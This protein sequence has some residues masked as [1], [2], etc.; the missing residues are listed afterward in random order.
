MTQG[1]PVW[2][3]DWTQ[4]DQYPDP[5]KMTREDWAWE[6]LRR[7][8]NYQKTWE[9]VRKNPD[10]YIRGNDFQDLR[11]KNEWPENDPAV[12]SFNK[13]CASYWGLWGRMTPP[14][15]T[16]ANNLSLNFTTAPDVRTTSCY[17]MDDG[18][19][20]HITGNPSG[21]NAFVVVLDLAGS[22]AS[23]VKF[24]KKEALRLKK[25]KGLS[26]GR[27]KPAKNRTVCE[28]F[29]FDLR[30]YDAT[31]CGCSPKQIAY[32]MGGSDI[33]IADVENARDRATAAVDSH[34]RK[35]P[36][37]KNTGEE[38]GIRFYF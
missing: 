15:C 3:P 16:R 12:W 22:V 35:I 31:Q 9:R 27:S 18:T 11:Q 7:N 38:T 33:S 26:E 10:M 23:Q 36:M 20:V 5:D 17:K 28:T 30:C 14:E 37:L 8:E 2:I 19:Q 25:I 21:G 29:L 34:F 13:A 32:E 4:K 24:V 6:F 1:K